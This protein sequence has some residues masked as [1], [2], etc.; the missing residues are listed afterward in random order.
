[1]VLASIAPKLPVARL[2]SGYPHGYRPV[3]RFELYHHQKAGMRNSCLLLRQHVKQWFLMAH[4]PGQFQDFQPRWQRVVKEG[5]T[6]LAD[7][8]SRT[9]TSAG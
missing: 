2:R 4:V 6:G 9:I 1:M 8:A 7:N 5:H 3:A